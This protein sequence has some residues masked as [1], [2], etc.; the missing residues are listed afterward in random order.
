MIRKLELLLKNWKSERRRKHFGK[1]TKGIIYETENGIIS[2]PHEDIMIGKHLSKKGSWNLEEIEF[3]KQFIKKDDVV[4][5]VGTHVGTLLIPISRYCSKIVGYEANPRTFWF[6]K[7]NIF[8]N[9]VENATVF[10]LAAGDKKQRV[11]F[12]MNKMNT[13]GS[14]IKP[15][16]YLF[17]YRFDAPEEVEVEM[18]PLDNHIEENNLPVPKGIIMDIEGA[19]FYALQGMTQTL[20]KIRFLYMEYVPHHLQ[21]VSVTTNEQLVSLLSPYFD[22]VVSTHN[23]TEFD[24]SSSTSEF[25]NYLGGLQEADKADDLLFLKSS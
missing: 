14:K 24:I 21:N 18:V 12:L 9:S 22:K 3:L 19:E 17:R 4:Y 7:Q 8:S 23:K 15:V 6:L 2:M 1:F 10:N 16:K 25:L 5:I 20:E 11:Q 13:G